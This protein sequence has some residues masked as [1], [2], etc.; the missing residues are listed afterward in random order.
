M[1]RILFPRLLPWEVIIHLDPPLLTGLTRPTHTAQEVEQPQPLNWLSVCRHTRGAPFGLAPGGVYLAARITAG[2]G[3]LLTHPFTL[4][5]Q[6]IS[7]NAA[8][9]RFPFCGTIPA[10]RPG[11][12]LATTV[13]CGVRTFLDTR[14]A[15]VKGTVPVSSAAAIRSSRLGITLLGVLAFQVMRVIHS[16]DDRIAVRVEL[17]D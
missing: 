12:P 9:R 5:C 8:G 1:S 10:G 11:L 6:C 3:A 13:L 17:H 16:A 14:P 15:P 4:T 7:S 2:A